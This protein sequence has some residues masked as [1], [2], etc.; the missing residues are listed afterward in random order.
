MK[1]RKNRGEVSYPYY[2]ADSGVTV[3]SSLAET[4]IRRKDRHSAASTHDINKEAATPPKGAA[5][6]VIRSLRLPHHADVIGVDAAVQR[7]FFDP[8]EAP[9][10]CFGKHEDRI[11]RSFRHFRHFQRIVSRSA[12]RPD[13]RPFLH[14]LQHFLLVVYL[15]SNLLFIVCK[16][17]TTFLQRFCLLDN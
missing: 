1:C 14:L 8:V 15:A 5:V 11:I 9:E 7:L 12:M 13:T 17:L 16:L 4:E 10:T 2:P 3:T 6:T